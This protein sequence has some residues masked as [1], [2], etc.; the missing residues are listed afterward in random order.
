MAYHQK[1]RS[2]CCCE[3]GLDNCLLDISTEL[4]L[5]VLAQ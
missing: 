3:P 1:N 5:R 4:T 2:I